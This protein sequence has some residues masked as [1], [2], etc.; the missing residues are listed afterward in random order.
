MSTVSKDAIRAKIVEMICE[1]T[2][3]KAEQIKDTSEF[4]KDII[5]DSLS[6]AEMLMELEEEFDVEIPMEEANNFKL[7]SDLVGYLETHAKG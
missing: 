2:D 1:N 7:L 5:L 6:F 3:L 4:N